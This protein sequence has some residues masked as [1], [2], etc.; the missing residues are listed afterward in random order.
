MPPQRGPSPK[1]KPSGNGEK[2]VPRPANAWI[3]FRR[4]MMESFR[5]QPGNMRLSQGELSSMFAEMW[6]A[7]PPN[8]RSYYESKARDAAAKHKELH[9]NYKY[10]PQKKEEKLRLAAEK[11]AAAA[12]ERERA[13]AAKLESRRSGTRSVSVA[14]G[15]TQP[16]TP[17]YQRPAPY[18]IP[19]LRSQ[20]YTAE[21]PSGDVDDRAPTP[22]LLTP[23]DEIDP[24]SPSELVL[25]SSF[26]GSFGVMVS[27]ASQLPEASTSAAGN[28]N[29]NDQGYPRGSGLEFD[30][31]PQDHVSFDGWSNGH[32]D[33][34][35]NHLQQNVNTSLQIYQLQDF[36]PTNNIMTASNSELAVNLGPLPPAEEPNFL[37]P[38]FSDINSGLFDSYSSSQT[39]NI[40]NVSF[41]DGFDFNDFVVDFPF[42]GTSDFSSFSS[43]PALQPVE[44]SMASSSNSITSISSAEPYL[45]PS[46]AG[47]SN[48]R[49]AASYRK[50][51]LPVSRSSSLTQL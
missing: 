3:I 44:N 7:L 31:S 39:S 47:N 50:D 12:A 42:V 37:A 10:Q 27:C 9:P 16:S 21:P 29:W 13:A 28:G 30:I 26:N 8:E 14:A 49:V 35:V 32:G 1:P 6:R 41:S 38:D 34:F 46:G 5:K 18:Y 15:S 23:A 33:S 19:D 43:S 24:P 2:K 4:D 48:R 20:H 40:S 22:P 45:P 17:Q 25:A 36:D 51:S 11:K